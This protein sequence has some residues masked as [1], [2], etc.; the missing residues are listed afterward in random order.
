MVHFPASFII[1]QIP[2]SSAIF[3]DGSLLVVALSSRL[4]RMSG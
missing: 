3:L 1:R 2:T 4:V